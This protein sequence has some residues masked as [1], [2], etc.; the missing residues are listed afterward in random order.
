M[1]D[2]SSQR[3][4]P[5]G[6]PESPT[7][8]EIRSAKNGGSE[9][10]RIITRNEESRIPLT[11]YAF[12]ILHCVYEYNVRNFGAREIRRYANQKVKNIA[13]PQTP[14]VRTAHYRVT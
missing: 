12:R 3:H 10:L 7:C 6:Y 5:K 1:F 9:K 8:V 2:F 14:I 11:S 4:P 13:T